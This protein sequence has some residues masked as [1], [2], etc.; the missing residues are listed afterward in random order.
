MLPRNDLSRQLLAAVFLADT[1]RIK[2]LLRLRQHLAAEAD[3]R[4]DQPIHHAA[5]NGDTE[6]V[7]VLLDHG[8]DANAIGKAEN[9]VL[10]CAGGHGHLDISK[11]LLQHGADV[12]AP[13]NKTG[14]T[15]AQWL[16]QFPD[17]KRFAPIAELL[18]ERNS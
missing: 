6:V 10:Y 11:L 1:N 18:E 15:L 8:A 14:K 7:Q 12:Q 4:G 3:G 16:A 2:S 5:R 17:D 9:T 13:C